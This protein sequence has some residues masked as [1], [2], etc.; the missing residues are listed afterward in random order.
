[1]LSRART[2][3]HLVGADRLYRIPLSAAR[4]G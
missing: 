3:A 4:G 1:V 2:V